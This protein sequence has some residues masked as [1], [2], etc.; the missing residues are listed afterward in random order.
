MQV[1]WLCH[2]VKGLG[3]DGHV[4]AGDRALDL[5]KAGGWNWDTRR[6]LEPAKDYT[7]NKGDLDKKPFTSKGR[8]LGIGEGRKKGLPMRTGNLK[9][10]FTW[11][12]DAKCLSPA[13]SRNLPGQNISMKWFLA[14]GIART[15]WQ[16]Q[17]KTALEG[18]SLHRTPSGKAALNTTN[19]E[20]SQNTQ[21]DNHHSH[22]QNTTAGLNPKSSDN[23]I[24]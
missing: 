22:C 12:W 5:S 11:V 8:Q 13:R 23:R 7:F 21:R 14:V 2:W 4:E 24:I 16:K 15:T 6:K 18:Q 19:N 20:K 3:F 1:A 9:P 10:A 17:H